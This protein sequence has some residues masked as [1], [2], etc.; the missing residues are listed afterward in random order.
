MQISNICP[1][2]GSADCKR[3][4]IQ[5][6]DWDYD[7]SG[8]YLICNKGFQCTIHS[9]LYFGDDEDVIKRFNMIYAFLLKNHMLTTEK[10][11]REYKFFYQESTKM[12]IIDDATKVNVARLMMNYPEEFMEKMDAALINLSIEYRDYGMAI[13]P[14]YELFRT[15]YCNMMQ[16]SADETETSGVLDM[17]ADLNYLNK[18]DNNVYEISADGW[19]HI[20]EMKKNKSSNH[21]FMAMSFR[22]ETQKI[23]NAFKSAISKCGYEPR[24]IDEK[25]HNNQIVPE[26]L[27]EIRKSKFVVVD[28]TYPNYGAYYEAGYAEALGKQVIICCRSKEF[29][30]ENKPH[31]DI[32]QKSAVVWDSEEELEERLI[33][34][35]EATVGKNI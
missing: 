34:R 23:S 35:I 14:G 13:Y 32:A 15:L 29:N 4:P 12:E 3:M 33:R 1:L 10:G 2:C 20:Y 22:N 24:R 11:K 27:Y 19:K 16:Y 8:F 18:N 6:G 31:F 28:I 17:L 21:G 30:G 7:K 26:I 5:D 9:D 25:E